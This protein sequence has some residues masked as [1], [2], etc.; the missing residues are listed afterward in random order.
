MKTTYF[1]FLCLL[2][3]TVPFLAMAQS[4]QIIN[5][6]V[7][8]G[9]IR[10]RTIP[11]TS[12]DQIVPPVLLATSY[13]SDKTGQLYGRIVVDADITFDASKPSSNLFAI[14]IAQKGKPVPAN[15]FGDFEHLSVTPMPVRIEYFPA[16]VEDGKQV[17]YYRV[18]TGLQQGTEYIIHSFLR[19][20]SRFQTVPNKEISSSPNA[21]TWFKIPKRL[22]MSVSS[23]AVPR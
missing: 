7:K 20:N 1:L 8:N 3:G 5:S 23:Y 4:D 19:Y 2:L 16:V 17:I 11:T 6:K 21:H 18:A 14:N 22:D 15:T 13:P 12:T 9:R 10:T